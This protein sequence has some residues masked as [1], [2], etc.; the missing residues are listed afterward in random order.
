MTAFEV[1]QPLVVDARRV[2]IRLPCLRLG[3]YT[4]RPWL[5]EDAG[6]IAAL[7]DPSFSDSLNEAR[8]HALMEVGYTWERGTQGALGYVAVHEPTATLQG[9]ALLKTWHGADPLEPKFHRHRSG[10]LQLVSG[11]EVYRHKIR[12][13]ELSGACTSPT[14]RGKGLYAA[15]FLMRLKALKALAAQCSPV[16]LIFVSNL[17]P[18]RPADNPHRIDYVGR[19]EAQIVGNGFDLDYDRLSKLKD[20]SG[21]RP[22]LVT[23]VQFERLM[24]DLTT[25]IW[26]GGQTITRT[27]RFG[28]PRPSSAIAHA[29]SRRSINGEA[30]LRRLASSGGFHWRA[31]VRFMDPA[32]M[33]R[34]HGGSYFIA[35]P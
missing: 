4:I 1:I 11:E 18:L 22:I 34:V 35:T 28:D 5:P 27:Y 2:E 6:A 14:H 10:G 15:M 9:R 19:I 16:E 24:E 26:D 32:I 33:H 21:E 3:D 17:G 25:M 20:G 30:L 12:L 29:M 31:P 13:I 23:A 7:S 8:I